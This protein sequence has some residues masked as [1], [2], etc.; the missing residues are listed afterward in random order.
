MGLGEHLYGLHN[1][2]GFL[3]GAIPEIS[4]EAHPYILPSLRLEV[5]SEVFSVTI[6]QFSIA[7]S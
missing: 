5:T 7:Q 1:Q 3:E 6:S 4:E 2:G